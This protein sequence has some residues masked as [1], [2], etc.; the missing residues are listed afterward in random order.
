M[1]FKN[2]FFTLLLIVGSTITQAQEIGQSLP[3]W[4]NGM[5]DL[6]HISTG[7]GDAAFYILPDGTT[8][9]Y[10]V[11]ELSEDR[12][13]I[14]SSRNT[15]LVPNHDKFAHEWVVDY[16]F[17]FGPKSKNTTIDYGVVSHF[18]DDHFGEYSTYLPIDKKTGC[19]RS[20]IVGVGHFVEIHKMIDRDYPNY[21]NSP[22][23]LKKNITKNK[24]NSE[25]DRYAKSIINYW[26]FLDYMKANEGMKVEKFITGSSNQIY[27]V[28]NNSYANFK[29]QNIMGNGFSWT[30]FDD[31]V[32]DLNVNNENDLSVGI[33]ISYGEF[34][35]FTGGDISGVGETGQ[36]DMNSVESQIAPVIGA[37]DVATLNHHGNRNSQNEFYVRTVRPRVWVQQCWSSDHPG[38]EVLRRISSKY[39]YP[40]ERD[41]Y[42]TGML[43]ANKLVIGDKV[44][45]L[46]KSQQG[47]VLIRVAKGGETYKVI[48]LDDK[49][50]DKKVKAVFGPY[51]SR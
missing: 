28:N 1:E 13:R 5:M 42:T 31:N 27:L 4:E 23:N 47:H 37:V 24:S 29:I 9:L 11:G 45:K 32:F 48:I 25:D 34:D 17:D 2:Q 49:S 39:L 14:T 46:Y 36:S 8:V 15:P 10:D 35:Y 41:I 43:E 12:P 6:H 30:G 20:G 16:I 26:N 33:R 50:I 22:V 21:E 3:K 7:R 19:Q 18:H 51:K 44:D 38:E 40:G